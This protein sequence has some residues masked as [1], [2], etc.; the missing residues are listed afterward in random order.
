MVK[1]NFIPVIINNRHQALSDNES[2]NTFDKS[3]EPNMNIFLKTK[4]IKNT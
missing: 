1:V 4:R 3:Q 2:Q